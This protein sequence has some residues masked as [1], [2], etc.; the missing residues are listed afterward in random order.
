MHHAQVTYPVLELQ[1]GHAHV[2][3]HAERYDKTEA[4][5]QRYR[6]AGRLDAGTLGT[7]VLVDVAE[8][9]PFDLLEG[10]RRIVTAGVGTGLVLTATNRRPIHLVVPVLRHLELL[11]ATVG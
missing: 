7:D 4:G 9:W 2:A 5:H 8:R 10:H 6:V 3:A 1:L 11:E